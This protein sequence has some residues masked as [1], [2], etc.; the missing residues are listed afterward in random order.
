MAVTLVIL[1]CL[2]EPPATPVGHASDNH[3]LLATLVF[4]APQNR[5]VKSPDFD[6]LPAHVAASEGRTSLNT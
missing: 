4:S 6:A 3:L 2:D 5:F 1:I